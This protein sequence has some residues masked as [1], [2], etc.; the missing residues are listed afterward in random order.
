MLSPV[1]GLRPVR[2]LRAETANVPK[3]EM[4]TLSPLRRAPTMSSKTVFTARSACPFG[5]SS[6]LATDS[7]RSAFVMTPPL[8]RPPARRPLLATARHAVNASRRRDPT[9]RL[10]GTAPRAP[11]RCPREAAAYAGRPPDPRAR[12]PSAAP[13]P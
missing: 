4:L 9:A 11:A 6:L 7:I 3:P 5:R 13:G 12:A 2:A 8:V 10:L 1:L